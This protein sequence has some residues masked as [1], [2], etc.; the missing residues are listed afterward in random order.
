MGIQ[1][2]ATRTSL[3]IVAE[4]N[5]LFAKSLSTMNAEALKYQFLS[6]IAPLPPLHRLVKMIK[7]TFQVYHIYIFVKNDLQQYG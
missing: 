5:K 7:H 4:V 3:R 2:V 1:H 6:K